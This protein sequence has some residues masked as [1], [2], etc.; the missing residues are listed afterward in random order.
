MKS[1]LLVLSASMALLAAGCSSVDS[2]MKKHEE[3]FNT[4]PPAVQEKVRAGEVDVGFTEEMVLVAL[5]EPERRYSRTTASGQADAWV[6]A[7]KSPKFSIGLGVGSMRGS[8]GVGGGVTLGGGD[9]WGDNEA[10]RV[11]FEGGRVSAIER[12]K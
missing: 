10:L 5:G 8:S 1:L 2:R 3:A 7:D 4:W 11:I 12:R 9:R 6:Y